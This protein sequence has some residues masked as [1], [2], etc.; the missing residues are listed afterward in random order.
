MINNRFV[1]DRVSHLHLRRHHP[2]RSVHQLS[3][4]SLHHFQHRCYLL[5]RC[6]YQSASSS[7]HR[8]LAAEAEASSSFFFTDIGFGPF[9]FFFLGPALPPLSL[10]RPPLCFCFTLVNAASSTSVSRPPLLHRLLLP[11]EPL[12]PHS[13]PPSLARCRARTAAVCQVWSAPTRAVWTTVR[14]L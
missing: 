12:P 10:S 1:Q 2:Q 14:P 8:L 3:S 6:C 4:A 11:I 5:R 9:A 7:L 13:A